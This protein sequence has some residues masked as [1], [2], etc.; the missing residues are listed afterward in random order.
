MSVCLD[1]NVLGDVQDG[2][3]FS[4]VTVVSPFDGDRLNPALASVLSKA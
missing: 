2:F 3:R 1:T 4:G